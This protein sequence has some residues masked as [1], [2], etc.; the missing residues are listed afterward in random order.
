MWHFD[1]LERLDG[2][3]SFQADHGIAFKSGLAT[4]AK[5]LRVTGK[6]DLDT[7]L[8]YVDAIE[9][10]EGL[11]DGSPGLPSTAA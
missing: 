4:Q 10:A 1:F 7:R 5:G 8:L 6:L 11:L 3:E 9:P 2:V